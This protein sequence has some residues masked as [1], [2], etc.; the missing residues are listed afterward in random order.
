MN[1]HIAPPTVC[2]NCNTKLFIP[3]PP[4]PYILTPLPPPT[5]THTPTSQSCA[6][7]IHP[8]LDLRPAG[9]III[10]VKLYGQLTGMKPS[11]SLL[12]FLIV[13]LLPSSS[14]LLSLSLL[15]PPPSHSPS[16]SPYPHPT[17][18]LV[19][20]SYLLLPVLVIVECEMCFKM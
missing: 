8:Q 10:Q 11:C 20:F 16:L 2:T 12:P 3:D 17:S 4:L 14:S 5:S 9:K 19:P 18:S 6:L 15:L 7:H 1:N 13:P